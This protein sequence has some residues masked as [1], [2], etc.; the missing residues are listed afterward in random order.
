M[1]AGLLLVAVILAAATAILGRQAQQNAKLAVSERD[2]ASARELSMAAVNNLSEDPELSM[3]LALESLAYTQTHEA[4]NALHWAI[5]ASRLRVR[6]AGEPVP[7]NMVTFHPAGTTI[8]TAGA[9]GVARVWNAAT[10][11]LVRELT[12]HNDFIQ[13]LTYSPDGRSLATAGNDFTARVWDLSTGQSIL[14]LNHPDGVDDVDFDPNGTTLATASYDGGA[15]IWNLET[16]AI[17]QELPVGGCINASFSPDGSLLATT[18]LDL[19][20]QIWDLATGEKRHT[21]Q[22]HTDVVLGAKFSPDGHQLATVGKDTGPL[23][24]DVDSGE[25]LLTPENNVFVPDIAY[26]PDGQQIALAYADGDV[27]VW[28][29][30]AFMANSGSAPT[31]KLAGHESRVLGVDFDPSGRWLATAGLDGTARIWDLSEAGEAQTLVHENITEGADFSPDGRYL[32]IGVYETGD[33]ILWDVATGS[34]AVT[35]NQGEGYFW[36]TAFSPDGQQVAAAFWDGTIAVWDLDAPTEVLFKNKDHFADRALAGGATGIA[37]SPMG[38]LLAS[39]G[40]NGKAFLWDSETGSRLLTISGHGPSAN[41][42]IFEG[43]FSVAVSPDGKWLATGGADGN[44]MVWD[45]TELY[46]GRPVKQTMAA[47]EELFTLGTHEA[48]ILDVGFSP[49]GRLVASGDYNGLAV[50]WDSRD[51][52]TPLRHPECHLGN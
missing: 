47:G 32:A 12:G 13:D 26:S 45:I 24:W 2:L 20:A 10:G 19:T 22:G 41:P 36:E 46:T 34:P 9:D 44:I 15:K 29:L 16:G 30:D 38:Q 3:L 49:D 6:T 33:V 31:I 18:S 11:E 23:I 40:D 51:S 21:L 8:A 4:E 52:R 35:L 27:A 37:Y 25:L 7:M 48:T 1:L 14:K 43:I 5:Q 28:D 39:V 50:V 42:G 17:E